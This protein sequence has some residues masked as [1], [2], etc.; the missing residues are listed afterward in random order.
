[1]GYKAFLDEKVGFYKVYLTQNILIHINLTQNRGVFPSKTRPKLLN[2]VWVGL[3]DFF[4]TPTKN[5][6]LDKVRIIFG[7]SLF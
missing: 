7:I 4:Y 5:D 1:M 2:S 6:I 3:W